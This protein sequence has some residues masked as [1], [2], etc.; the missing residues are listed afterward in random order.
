VAAGGT[1]RVEASVVSI[2][3]IPREAVE[4]MARLPFDAGMAAYDLPPPDRVAPGELLRL[5]EAGAFRFANELRAFVE[6]DDDAGGRPVRWG[7]VGSGH[8]GTTTVAFGERDVTFRAV[9]L[10][11][12]RP[13]PV[14]GP[15]SV[16][17]VQ[18]AGGRTGAPAP[19][20]V[21]RPPFVQLAAPVAWTTLALTVER[22]GTS[23][24]ELAGASPF[25]RHWIYD[26]AGEHVAKSGLIDFETW[27]R[28][29]F[30][31]QT[32]WG[33]RDS[34]AILHPAASELER[35]VSVLMMDGQPDMR[36]VATGD[37]LVRQGD[38]GD[39]LFLLLDGVLSVEV[40][41]TA[42]TEVG[43][44]AVLGEMALLSDGRRRATLR[45]VTAVRV[46]VVPG[47]LIHRDA[48]ER[49]RRRREP[50]A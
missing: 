9:A 21:R 1:R 39:E 7:S 23:S 27:W 48:L 35:E 19:R 22:N 17:F 32:P 20:R 18:T 46:G 44:G 29:A 45:A 4:G 30:G 31:D 2:S 12:L 49:I 28:E 47:S 6:F 40:D 41:G 37:T 42:V 36:R 38:P 8:I 24:W 10:P 26:A 11:D 34:V 33:G 3:W 43:P 14:V 13:D 50:E 5:R 15:T 25:P 16:R